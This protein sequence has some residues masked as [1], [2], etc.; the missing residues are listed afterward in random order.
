[1]PVLIETRR[2]HIQS[3]K[4]THAPT[5]MNWAVNAY[6]WKQDRQ[7]VL[8]VMMSEWKYELTRQEWH[9]VLSL[10]VPYSIEYNYVLIYI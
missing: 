9:R 2:V 3:T 1:M 4:T 6:T 5:M 7:S 10:K 8:K